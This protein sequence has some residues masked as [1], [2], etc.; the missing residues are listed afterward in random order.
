VRSHYELLSIE[1]GLTLEWRDPARALPQEKVSEMRLLLEADSRLVDLHANLTEGPGY[2]LFQW[3]GNLSV[4]RFL[5]RL[6]SR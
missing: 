3:R 1:L 2:S 6:T 4:G 5:F